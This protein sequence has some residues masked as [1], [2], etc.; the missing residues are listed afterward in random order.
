[1]HAPLEPTMRYPIALLICL[2]TALAHAQ[3]SER[4]DW[5]RNAAMGN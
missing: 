4:S 3:D 1:M 5:L 2:G